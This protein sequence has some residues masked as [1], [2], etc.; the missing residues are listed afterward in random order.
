M[1]NFSNKNKIHKLH[2]VNK[3]NK[4][5]DYLNRNKK[6]SKISW[7]PKQTMRKSFNK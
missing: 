7:K 2:K 1:K 4:F 6:F 3:W 5:K